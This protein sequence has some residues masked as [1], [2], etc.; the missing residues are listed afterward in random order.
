MKGQN[1]QITLV[2]IMIDHE[3]WD[4]SDEFF[5][6]I[7]DLWGAHSIDRFASIMNRKTERFNSLFWNPGSERTRDP[8]YIYIN[9]PL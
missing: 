3:D 5:L 6:F 9:T 2:F 1:R 4:V 7:D 8:L